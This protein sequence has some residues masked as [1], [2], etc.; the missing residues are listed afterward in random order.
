[1]EPGTKWQRSRTLTSD[2]GDEHSST[3][4]PCSAQWG[5]RW[6]AGWKDRPGGERR[7]G[8]SEPQVDCSPTWPSPCLGARVPLIIE[9]WGWEPLPECPCAPR[10]SGLNTLLGITAKWLPNLCYN[11]SSNRELTTSQTA[12]AFPHRPLVPL[13]DLS[14]LLTSQPLPPPRR[15]KTKVPFR[16]WLPS[17]STKLSKGALLI[18]WASWFFFVAGGCPIHCGIFSS[19]TGLHPLDFRSTPS[20]ASPSCGNQGCLQTL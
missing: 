13:L 7:C 3:G 6:Q 9:I 4:W 2:L 15:L 18:F 1:M 8:H 14:F 20:P 12:H 10:C 5:S 17:F 19:I 16:D 11:T